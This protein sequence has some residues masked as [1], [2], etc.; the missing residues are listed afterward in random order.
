MKV[1]RSPA[2][3]LASIGIVAAASVGLA[4]WDRP[5]AQMR[6][7]QTPVAL[8]IHGGGWTR[9]TPASGRKLAPFFARNRFDFRAVSYPKPPQVKLAATVRDLVGQVNQAARNGNPPITLIG[10]SAG[11]ELAAAVAFDPAVKANV[12]CVILFDGVGYDLPALVRKPV[13][14]QR[15]ALSPDEAQ[16]ISPVAQLRRSSRRPA[17]YIAAASP[18]HYAEA[19]Q[20]ADQAK[21][22]KI[23]VT[24]VRFPGLNHVDFVRSFDVPGNGLMTGVQR[25][26]D[27]H[28]KCS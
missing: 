22:L 9:G 25:F 11:A 21:A 6:S 24:L 7:S 15:L 10:H 26:I 8:F 3:W 28:R 4:F 13:W 5:D 14:R 2:T 23:D 20:F 18:G 12:R 17:L 19:K 16:A 27:T 1:L